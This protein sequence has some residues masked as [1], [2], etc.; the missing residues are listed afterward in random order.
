MLL[1]KMTWLLITVLLLGGCRQKTDPVTQKSDFP[2]TENPAAQVTTSS[3]HPA[4]IESTPT[5]KESNDPIE[6]KI[7]TQDPSDGKTGETATGGQIQTAVLPEELNDAKPPFTVLIASGQIYY[8]NTQLKKDFQFSD[9]L[10]IRFTRTNNYVMVVDSKESNYVLSPEGYTGDASLAQSCPSSGCILD[11]VVYIGALKP[12]MGE[13]PEDLK[14][15][16][17]RPD[18]NALMNT[19]LRGVKAIYYYKPVTDNNTKLM[20][21]AVIESK[22]QATEFRKTEA[23][24]IQKTEVTPSVEVKMNPQLNNASEVKKQ[25]VIRKEAIRKKDN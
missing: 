1:K 11:A 3:A 12:M 15:M 7:V 17:E 8:E 18:K 21:S 22:V 9:V 13:L 4:S 16:L 6:E 19:R 10:K 2:A 5:Q 24:E 20:N 23:T 14:N 25:T